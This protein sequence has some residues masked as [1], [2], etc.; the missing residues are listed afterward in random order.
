MAA[1]VGGPL[2]AALLCQHDRLME[3]RRQLPV[4]SCSTTSSLY[5]SHH[6][7]WEHE[8]TL[9]G[10]Q[11]GEERRIGEAFGPLHFLW[12]PFDQNEPAVPAKHLAIAE[13]W[14]RANPTW[15]VCFWTTTPAAPLFQDSD[16]QVASIE[17]LLEHVKMLEEEHC[18]SRD[19]DS[20]ATF[21]TLVLACNVL[22]KTE[23]YNAVDAIKHF[24]VWA[25]GGLYMDLDV[26]LEGGGIGQLSPLFAPQCRNAKFAALS[27]FMGLQGT[28]RYATLFE[29]QVLAFP[30]HL[31]TVA[32]DTI[33]TYLFFHFLPPEA[34]LQL[35]AA[36]RRHKRTADADAV[37]VSTKRW[38]RAGASAVRRV[39]RE[40]A[41][42]VRRVLREGG[43]VKLN[44]ECF[45]DSAYESQRAKKRFRL[46]GLEAA[47][48]Q[49]AE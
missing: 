14:Q 39:L 36:S 33:D 13:E 4:P 40:G 12:L 17:T 9:L 19:R 16:V 42:A 11:P 29:N 32:K 31:Q 46:R 23:G 35:R 25:C 22:T 28:T 2:T 7:S 47:K 49:F 30:K 5:P 38:F 10:L 26:R 15:Q 20:V 48:S 34:V 18:S 21:L 43:Q 3:R 41:S 8:R 45:F 24:I 27:H 6:S 37:R 44:A 1:A